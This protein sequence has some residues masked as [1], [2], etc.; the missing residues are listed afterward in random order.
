MKAAGQPKSAWQAEARP[1]WF[2][3]KFKT[4]ISEMNESIII[5]IDALYSVLWSLVV[6]SWAWTYLRFPP[7]MVW[8]NL[9]Q[10]VYSRETMWNMWK[11]FANEKR[12]NFVQRHRTFEV[13][14]AHWKWP[15]IKHP[16]LCN[17][18][19]WELDLLDG[20]KRDYFFWITAFLTKPTHCCSEA[21]F[22]FII[23][24]SFTECRLTPRT[25]ELSTLSPHLHIQ[26]YLLQVTI[27]LQLKTKYREI[28]SRHQ[29][30]VANRWTLTKFCLASC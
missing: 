20:N 10:S 28:D 18:N 6:A 9:N 24:G 8:L 19:L 12:Q 27:L 4:C 11:Y 25:Q 5:S 7:K 30:P 21:S 22:L 1:I 13:W 15:W 26:S 3:D 2:L 14:K 29:S 17:G 16:A 23:A